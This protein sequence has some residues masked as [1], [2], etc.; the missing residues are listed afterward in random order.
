MPNDRPNALVNQTFRQ[1][2]GSLCT[3]C[4]LVYRGTKSRNRSPEENGI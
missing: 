1:G 2:G 4:L 3:P